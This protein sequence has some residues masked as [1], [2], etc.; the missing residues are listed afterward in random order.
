MVESDK[1][2]IPHKTPAA[3]IGSLR[4]ALDSSPVGRFLKIL[5]PGFI[6]GA[7]DDDPSGIGTYTVAGAQLG[8][9]TLWLAVLTY[10]LMVT[11][12][13]ICAKIGMVSGRG[14]ASVL[15]TYYPR[16]LLFPAVIALVIANT[17]NA[18][19][20]I[21]AIAAALNLLVPI[22]ALI[23]V[24]PVGALLLALQ[25]FGSYH[26]I[27]RIFKWL[28]LALFAYVLTAFFAHPDWGAVAHATLVPTLRFDPLFLSTVVAILGTTISPYLF[29][30][31]TDQE[32]EEQI[33]VGRTTL[34]ARQGATDQ[35]IR[36]GFLDVN[37]GMFFSNLVMFFII[38]ATAS[39]LFKAGKTEI[40]SATDAA[41]ALRPLAGNA[42]SL[43]L[44]I[45]LI[46][47][48]CLAVPI[49]T[50]SAAYGIAEAFGW[51]HSLDAKPQR[52]RA[53]YGVIAGA[54]LI[55]IALNFVGINPI[56]ALFLSAVINGVLAPPLL[57]IILLVANNQTIMGRHV[58]GRVAN[59]LGWI[60][61][62]LMAVAALT[63]LILVALGKS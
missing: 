51:P 63:L 48:G 27:A 58:N 61:A 36:A 43:L 7:S 35:E 20:D 16:W 41:Q 39:T 3:G 46:G 60:T 4:A 12:Q 54:T 8:F 40:Q 29:F 30:W 26:V 28:T 59:I 49:L 10:P 18:G 57:V 11:V 32:V 47:S 45:G 13:F 34:K 5:G 50:G 37:V 31:Q 15:R 24:V 6:T 1:P 22:P 55:G 52:A 17:I 33:S 56:R 25:L 53:F 2:V 44:A 14:L 9:A 42:A 38:L 21:G 62:G 23:F 19:A